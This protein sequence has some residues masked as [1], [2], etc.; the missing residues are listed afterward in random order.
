VFGLAFLAQVCAT[1]AELLVATNSVWKYRKGTNEVSS[2]TN[3]WREVDFIDSI[4]S[5]GQAPIHYDAESVYVGNTALND[6]RY[7]YTCIFMRQ[8]FVVA[9]VSQI[10]TLQLQSYC[11]D[12][13]VAWIN[14]TRV[15]THNFSS[16]NYA[17]TNVASLLATEP[18]AWF[19]ATLTNPAA[20]LVTGTNVLAIQ[21]FNRPITSSD[22]IINVELASS[23][24][25]TRAPTVAAVT[26]TPGT[27]GS[28]T[29]IS[30][31]FSEPV[32]GV[33]AADLLV[34]TVPAVNVTGGGS[35]F[36]F[37]VDQ[38]PYGPV[39][40]TWDPGAAITD[41]ATPPNAFNP[42]GPG[43]T[44]QYQ[45]VDTIAP[46]V[47]ALSPAPGVTVR[48]LS[49]VSVT[50]SEP[51]VGVNAADLLLNG[52]QAT[53]VVGALAGPYVFEFA[54][55]SAGQVTLSWATGHNLRDE[56]SP[57]NAFAGGSW[58]V[59][60]DPNWV[61][62]P[63][64]LNEILTSYSGD[65]GL[66]DE[67]D[68]VQD[69]IELWNGGSNTVSLLG[70][71]LSDDRDNPAK[72]TFPAVSLSPGQYLVVFASGK[73]RK[74]TTPGARLH[75]NFKLNS[76]GDYLGLYNA[77]SPP[78]VMSAFAPEFPEQRSDYS[79]G[80]EGS[81]QLRYFS[82]PTPSA[83]NGTSTIVGVVPP[84]HFNVR[85]GLFEMPF[86]IILG[87]PMPEATIRYSTDGGEPTAT[88]GT[89]YSGPTAIAQTT[90]LRAAAF[91]PGYL[92]S[93][94][95]THTYVFLDQVITQ[96]AN[97]PGV[98]TVW[99]DNQNR[100]WIADYAMDPEV[101]QDP[102]YR[103]LMK[104]ALQALP[105]LSLVTKPQDLFDN[106]T[107]IYPK[108]Q[109]RGPS[110][111]RPCSAELILPDGTDGFQI[112]CGVQC[113]GNSARDP[114]KTPK[115]ALRLVFKG[116]Y[117][118]RKLDYPFFPDSS[119]ATYDTLT[120]RADFNLS[121]LHWDNVQRRIAQRSRDA[122]VKDV[123]RAMGG[124]ASHSRY[125]HLYLNGLYWGIYD[126]TERPDAG[127][128]QLYFGGEKADYDVVNEGALVDGNM[129]AY[130][131]MIGLTNLAD[132]AQYQLMQQYLD[133]TAYID[134]LL[135]QFYVANQDWGQN[136]NWYTLRRRAPGEGFKYVPWDSENIL[137]ATNYNRV[138]ST[139]TVSGL[140]AKLVTNTQY[141]LDFADRAQRHLF[142]SGPL[143]PTAGR[144]AWLKRSTE[145]EL[146]I[147][148]E[149]ARWGDY[150]RDVYQYSNGPYEFYTRNNQWYA[151]RDR[152]LNEYFP[153]RTAIVL[154]QLR[155][156]DL[157]PASAV[158]P[159]LS[160]FGGAVAR[161]ATL[162]MSV[163]S[164][165]IYYTT[166]GADPRVRYT[167]A[168]G[169]SARAYTAPLVLNDAVAIKARTL[170]GA[171]WS[172]LSEA[173]FQVAQLGIPLRITEIMYHPLGG[174][175]YEFV[176]IQNAGSTPLDVGS[177]AL[178]GVT[179]AFAP[180]TVLQPGQIIVLA[181]SLSPGSFAARY[182]GVT[183]FG[184]FKDSLANN[185]QRIGVRDRAGQW[186]TSVDYD[187]ENGW[188]LAADGPGYSLELLDPLGDP[189][190]P[191]NWRASTIIGGSPGSL[192]PGGGLSNLRLNEVMAD[193]VTAVPHGAAFPDWV[194]LHNAGA[195]EVD[196]AGWSLTDDSAPRK[197]VFPSG[198]RVPAGGYLVVWC[199]ATNIVGELHS[200]FALS[201]SGETIS[202]FDAATNRVDAVT[203][204][205]QLPDL[206]VGRVGTDRIWQLCQPTFGT[207]NIAQ[208][209]AASSSLVLNEW[210]PSPPSGEADW[211]EIHN[212]DAARPAALQGLYLT[213]GAAVFQLR[214]L[215]FIGPGGFVRL[216]AD[217]QP[218]PDHV[219]LALSASDGSMGLHD[220]AATL[221]DRVTYV[222]SAQ[223]VSE[224]RLPDGTAAIVGFA[225][226]ASPGASNYV[227]TYMGPRLNEVMAW[228]VSAVTDTAGGT[229]DWV[230]L[231]N[232]S[233]QAFNLGGLGLGDR[234]DPAARWLFPLNTSVP[235]Q[236]YLVV[237]FDSEQPA[238][239]N[240]AAVLNTGR[241]LDR[242]GGQVCLFNALGQIVDHLHYGLQVADLSLGLAGGTWQ[243]LAL[244]TPGQ[245]NAAPATL[246]AP[247]A[248]RINEW[249]AA[250]SSGPDWFEL[251]NLSSNPIALNGLYLT[252]SPDIS[253]LDRTPV[254]PLSYIGP[255]GFA[256]FDAVGSVPAAA[257]ERAFEL[258]GQGEA[259]LLLDANRQ[260]I[261]AVYYGAQT[262]DASEGRLPDGSAALV[263]FVA[264]PTPEASNYLPLTNAVINEVLTHTDPPWE[265]A[266][267]L[268]NPGT[269]DVA[270]GGWYLSDD[271]RDFKKYR[272]PD[273]TVLRAGGFAAFY[274]LQFNGGAGSL[275]PFL[276]DSVYGDTLYLSQADAGGNLT[277]YRSQRTF[278]AAANGV[279][280]GR[281]VTS[282]GENFVA[283]S[284]R[285]FGADQ[286]GSPE[287][288]RTGGGLPNAYPLVGP[289][290]VSEIMY[291]PVS[292]TGTNAV[293]LAEEE[294][295][296]L[297]NATNVA[298]ALFD[299][300]FPTNTWRLRDGVEFDF[301][302]NVTLPAGGFLVVV[303]FDPTTNPNALATFR[304]KYGVAET[305]PVLGPFRGRLGNGGDWLTLNRPDRPQPLGQ[306]DAGYVPYVLVEQVHYSDAS[307]W[308]AEADGSGASLQR[309][310]VTAYGNDPVNWLAATP[311]AGRTNLVTVSSNQ[312][313]VLTTLTDRTVDEGTNLAIAVTA[314]DPDQPLQTLT[315]SL[316]SPPT[317]AAIDPASGLFAWTPG[318]AQGP[319]TNTLTV[320][321]S[322]NGL[323]PAT[324]QRQFTVIVR[325]VNQGP[326]L[327]PL[328]DRTVTEH[329]LL[330]V[331]AVATD[332]DLPGN[333][334]VFS[335]LTSPAGANLGPLSGRF[336]WT[337]PE[338]AG[339]GV[340][341]VAIRV[342]DSGVPSLS[343]TQQFQVMVSE[344]NSPP[345]L[346]PLPNQTARPGE[347]LVLTLLAE[348][349]DLPLNNLRFSLLSGPA[350]ANVD[351]NTGR[352]SWT[353]G[354]LDAGRDHG[355][356]VGVSDDGSPN[357]ND[358]A[359]FIASVS[360]APELLIAVTSVSVDSVT[361]SWPA[362][363]GSTYRVQ[364]KNQLTAAVWTDLAGDVVAAGPAASKV[365]NSVGGLP[366]RFYRVTVLE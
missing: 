246:N 321:V 224:G 269:S 107:G 203:L 12:G 259:V 362:V 48:Q 39:A 93:R 229:A 43:A 276:L 325:E 59:F 310:S 15:H 331:D 129:T 154:D 316:L 248:L 47:V 207:S 141:R 236:G 190:D 279:S 142:N 355:F 81:S 29:Q 180:G 24:P 273:D 1:R 202:L 67:D 110:W 28:L 63:V 212:R 112:D 87:S 49:Q 20:Y 166:N 152:L 201:R 297:H 292:G 265:D 19:T 35:V 338:S 116:D 352:L 113:Q 50:F 289:I 346:L 65:A 126:P 179:Y 318:E 227:V 132:H 298:V 315:F 167:A 69:W 307:P 163:P 304:A 240:A 62:A 108:S 204:G 128:A 214:A 253:D 5:T 210:M 359:T 311:T 70:W 40:I 114:Q 100:S 198:T 33:S 98:P 275:V 161:G 221:M 208:P 45:L 138:A 247:A 357:L 350:H 320:R 172:A 323:P 348:D 95:G 145:L 351:A 130:N 54:P 274:Q 206:T 23:T 239:T 73:D 22:F 159:V 195:T 134:Y 270:L 287:E 91:R 293:E 170:L 358:S 197:F 26:P 176:E 136:K 364:Y 42:V 175:P 146:P 349:N 6:M 37:Q 76:D 339:P 300:S 3:A 120:L 147:V 82:V 365:D 313:P 252:D 356:T 301:P 220:A 194:E 319:S 46:T 347:P 57:A 9:D 291:H 216:W 169:A 322:D 366:E 77:E 155:A 164:G 103:D 125:V 51:V 11:D 32:T 219:D 230:E 290:V 261:D 267:E 158:A 99:I 228:N 119:A 199:D 271:P 36:T 340:Y 257:G 317:G 64:R 255:R 102:Q 363:P 101:T 177:F 343:S 115:H 85:R 185:G 244:P 89:L 8:K 324:D 264:T 105:I 232:P 80:Y 61:L 326:A 96:P 7:T 205:L 71:S 109:N 30:V 60:V 156:A 312:P 68:Q 184:Y 282:V 284:Q 286:P 31:T 4:W 344:A 335:L 188:P 13:F 53:S 88:T 251:F 181:S 127:F 123:Q 106:T 256:R 262:Q 341:P 151:E 186:I 223:G 162:T 258:D 309:Q 361:L 222:S 238:S 278:G 209:L 192:S 165:T 149:S 139:D 308:P 333:Q 234:E 245:P 196:L 150:R 137:N 327:A 345:L 83:T 18:L 94:I 237:W 193:N 213:A 86:T 171:E 296:E 153:V 353:P 329:V 354:A 118:A 143:T 231:F 173:T 58:T 260:L 27:V 25:D 241:G 52:A 281:F 34:N 44:W 178:E 189:D 182:P 78:Q 90:I 263:R 133:V 280:L 38:P 131:F 135:L 249:M 299:S 84:V 332:L 14:S 225:G 302:T 2:P 21:A 168:I 124:L 79:Y 235:A 277:G 157:Y 328:A 97:P 242:R 336:T 144:A 342:T 266:I 211:L 285:T 10:A 55:A 111:E 160:P 56:A 187:D 92:P 215:S 17:Y 72:W 334:L 360:A 117:G 254:G 294:Y 200:G 268:H 243:L 183:V 250:P 226:S 122:F 272:V 337:P 74:P 283:L 140:H 148:A 191:A 295:V 104:A 303:G 16:T 306:P 121:W 66:R 218:G 217:A 75:T 314:T 305:V 288:F 174:D 233:P 41:F 330:T